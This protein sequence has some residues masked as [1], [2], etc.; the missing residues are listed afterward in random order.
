MNSENYHKLGNHCW[1]A[2]RSRFGLVQTGRARM[3]PRLYSRDSKKLSCRMR[4]LRCR[5]MLDSTTTSNSSQLSC[6]CDAN[7]PLRL[8]GFGWLAQ[9]LHLR[10]ITLTL[11]WITSLSQRWLLKQRYIILFSIFKISWI[12]ILWSINPRIVYFKLNLGFGLIHLNC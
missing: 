10:P 5:E 6:D 8:E 4:G 3:L 7:P 12:T 11:Q 2:K 1:R 9:A